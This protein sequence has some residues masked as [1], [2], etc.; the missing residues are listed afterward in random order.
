MP[1]VD[2]LPRALGYFSL[3]LGSAQVLAPR[4]VSRLIG[5]RP[6]PTST[7]VMRLLGLRELGAGA[8]VLTQ[9]RP[10][11]WLWS[12][13]AGDAMDLSL[14]CAAIMDARND[15]AR[16]T[17]ALTNV[18]G[19]AAADVYAARQVTQ[20]VGGESKPGVMHL[21]KA[22]TVNKSPD[23]VYQ[24]WRD[25][26]N[27]P[28]FMSHLESVAVLDERR[29]HWTAKGPAGRLVEWDAEIIDD[30]PGHRIRWRSEPGAT[31]SNWGTVHFVAAPGDRGT[32]I[33]VDMD[34]APPAG[35]LGSFVA[36]LF[37]QEPSQQVQADLRKVKQVLETGEVTRSPATIGGTDLMQGP[38]QP[39]EG[40]QHTMG[41]RS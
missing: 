41:A 27:L 35:E 23:E 24:F 3:G 37:G 36:R 6:G 18:L 12:R 4:T 14:V 21:A 28:S 13:V 34:Y 40:R 39:L 1:A 30:V 32:E 31:V 19:V 15:R 20:A 29:S 22:V 10:A 25:F 38:A 33:H 8:G 26:R 7:T 9:S 2:V 5:I 16:L 11:F 17:V